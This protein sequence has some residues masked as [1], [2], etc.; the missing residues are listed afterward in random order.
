MPPLHSNQAFHLAFPV[1]DLEEARRFYAGILGCKV[2]RE[3]PGKWI[4]FDFG[5]HQISAHFRPEE[6]ARALGNVVDGDTVPTRH[7]GLILDWNHWHEL[8]RHLET[9]QQEFLIAPKTRFV[10]EAGEQATFFLLD[11]A[12]NALEFKSFKDPNRIFAHDA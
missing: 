7:F 12:G 6:C 10:G 9:E 11:P 3:D 4:D 5:G 2:G 8:A 1:D